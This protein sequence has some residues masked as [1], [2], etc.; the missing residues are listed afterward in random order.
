MPLVGAPVDQAALAVARESL[1]KVANLL[2][3]ASEELP[4]S[5]QVLVVMVVLVHQEP[6]ALPA[7]HLQEVQESADLRSSTTYPTGLLRP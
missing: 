4:A 5:L 7:G 3:S 6:E 1:Q 2:E